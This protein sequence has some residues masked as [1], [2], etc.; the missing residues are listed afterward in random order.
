MSKFI[1]LVV[2]A[3]AV[4]A[5]TDAACDATVRA[6]EQHGCRAPSDLFSICLTTQR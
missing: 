1:L 3:M 6:R 5:T 2:C 4:F